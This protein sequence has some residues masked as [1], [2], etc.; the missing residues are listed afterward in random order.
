MG[1]RIFLEKILYREF[2]LINFILMYEEF[3]IIKL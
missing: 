2:S 3:I 1:I